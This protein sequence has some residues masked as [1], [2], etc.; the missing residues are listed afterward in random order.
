MLTHYRNSVYIVVALLAI[1]FMYL[2]RPADPIDPVGIFLPT[3]KTVYSQIDIN[4]VQVMKTSPAGAHIIGAVRVEMHV[5]KDTTKQEQRVVE[6]ARELAA[7]AGANGLV[8]RTFRMLGPAGLEQRYMLIGQ[9]I[10]L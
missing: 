1:G 7:N 4:Q 5:D 9:A 6:Y 2:V 3:S 10:K 8:I